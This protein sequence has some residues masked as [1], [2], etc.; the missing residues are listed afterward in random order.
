MT[1]DRREIAE[2]SVEDYLAERLAQA[3]HPLGLPE[4]VAERFLAN[5]DETAERGKAQARQLRAKGYERPL[6]YYAHEETIET[7]LQEAAAGVR[8]AMAMAGRIVDAVPFEQQLAQWLGSTAAW[9]IRSEAAR[10]PRPP[11][12]PA[13]LAWSLA[14]VPWLDDPE[15]DWPPSGAAPLENANQLVDAEPARCEE[16]PYDGWVQIGFIERQRTL[17]PD[18]PP[19]RPGRRYSISVGL[20][21][22]DGSPPQRRQPFVSS[23]PAIWIHEATE[24]VPEMTSEQ[25]RLNLEAFPRHLAALLDFDDTP[26]IP[27]PN[28]APGLHPFLLAPHIELAALLGLR[29]EEPANRL[30]LVDDSG[31]ALV[32]RQWS[33]FILQDSR[34]EPIEPAAVGTD[35]LLRPDLY[36]QITEVIGPERVRLGFC[37]RL[38][39]QSDD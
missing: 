33:A 11:T 21:V 14:P 36:D 17:K 38:G 30:A 39:N 6:L 37:L 26:G 23:D 24:L 18:Y 20:E 27:Q 28:R 29:P 19:N 5:Y 31:L 7:A 35:I 34:Y 12:R 2:R 16:T 10:V 15:N 25:A 4:A 13:E 9:A 3:D 8:T 1:I 22:T 32:C